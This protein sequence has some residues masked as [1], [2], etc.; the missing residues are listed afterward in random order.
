MLT[1]KLSKKKPMRKKLGRA[2][3]VE[4]G[5]PKDRLAGYKD[6]RTG[7]TGADARAALVG[8]ATER[9]GKGFARMVG[10]R[11]KARR[12]VVRGSAY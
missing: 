8:S 4:A 11:K 12:G 3:V 6:D 9:N 7:F 2:V 10:K 5:L 1:A